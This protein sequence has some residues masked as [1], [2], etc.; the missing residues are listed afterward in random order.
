[1]EDSRIIGR[2]SVSFLANLLGRER[3]PAAKL[4]AALTSPHDGRAPCLL[5][6]ASAA[7]H[8]LPLATAMCDLLT[9]LARSRDVGPDRLRESLLKLDCPLDARCGDALPD[10]MRLKYTDFLGRL[11]GDGQ[12]E[13]RNDGAVYAVARL[14]DEHLLPEREQVV[15]RHS[16]TRWQKQERFIQLCDALRVRAPW[17]HP[18]PPPL[19]IPDL[20]GRIDAL[21]SSLTTARSDATGA[22]GSEWDTVVDS[23]VDDALAQGWRMAREQHEAL[24]LDQVSLPG[25]GL[26]IGKGGPLAELCLPGLGRLPKRPPAPVVDRLI[27]KVLRDPTLRE[28]RAQAEV[29]GKI[30]PACRAL[31][32]ETARRHVEDALDLSD[33]LAEFLPEPQ[34][35]CYLVRLTSDGAIR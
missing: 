26:A 17:Q 20:A 13:W 31:V 4:L 16:K 8:D 24:F 30:R 1:M 21:Q 18:E 5:R 10:G 15:S 3:L 22:R 34:V 2:E 6:L 23:C 19:S 33:R 35:D 27:E 12:G 7:V 14:R 28:S 29:S 32:A 11:I 9:A 25:S